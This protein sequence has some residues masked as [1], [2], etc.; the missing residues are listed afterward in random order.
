MTLSESIAAK[1]GID[2]Q[3]DPQLNKSAAFG[4][5][6][7]TALLLAMPR[8]RCHRFTPRKLPAPVDSGRPFPDL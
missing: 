4:G 8:P 5:S 3:R 6:L 1:L 7:S 2:R